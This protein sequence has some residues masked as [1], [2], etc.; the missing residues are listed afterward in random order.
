MEKICK[1]KD[2]KKLKENQVIIVNND[3]I[4]IDNLNVSFE[5]KNNI[6][7]INNSAKITI[8]NTNIK[9]KGN[10]SIV[11][12]NG[13]IFSCILNLDIYNNSVFYMGRNNYI[14]NVL[15]VIISEEKNVIIGNECLFSFGIWIRTADPHLIYS[16]SDHK[17]INPSKSVFVGDHVWVGQNATILKGSKIGSGSIIAASSLVSK[18]V[19]SNQIVGGN[20]IKTIKQNIFWDKQ[21]THAFDS[22]KTEESMIF[23]TDDYIFDK[24][25]SGF[26]EKID[27]NLEILKTEDKIDYLKKINSTHNRFTI[28]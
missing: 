7:F 15:N 12:L 1:L 2:I 24:D 9:F 22:K 16:I 3:K 6:L 10:N 23:E 28:K 26:F 5:G 11:F 8:K 17:R 14:N 13:S 25:N 20:P 4:D 18:K 21:S 27:K 19:S